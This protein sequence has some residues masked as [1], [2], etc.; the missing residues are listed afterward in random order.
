LILIDRERCTGCGA[1]LEICPES[2]IY[3]FEGK[4]VVDET[5]CRAC[6]VC[7]AACPEGAIRVAEA[8]A[9]AQPL[10]A[11]Q[12]APRPIPAQAQ[13]SL[14]KAEP[15][16]LTLSLRSRVL[17]A[18]GAALAWT[19]REIGPVLADYL[20]RRLEQRSARSRKDG[21]CRGGGG[22]KRRRRRRRG[23]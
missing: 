2:A 20:A 4:A 7:V 1:C 16:P 10:P 11:E 18:V 13:P 3:L 22:G 8:P 15:A 5:L 17:P 21:E 9:E 23:G 6:A 14:V 12:S 19:A